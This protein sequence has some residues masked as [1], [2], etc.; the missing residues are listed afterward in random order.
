MKT[1][2][3]TRDDLK[4]G[5]TNYEKHSFRERKIRLESMQ[6]YVTN[7]SEEDSKEIKQKLGLRQNSLQFAKTKKRR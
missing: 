2:M 4:V 1:V 6:E 3:E 7:L 5:N